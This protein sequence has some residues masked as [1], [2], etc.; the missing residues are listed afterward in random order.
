MRPDDFAGTVWNW[1]VGAGK[2][3]VCISAGLMCFLQGAWCATCTLDVGAEK[4]IDGRTPIRTKVRTQFNYFPRRI[5]PSQ[6]CLFVAFR[7]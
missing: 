1:L 7:Q 3:Q 4:G 5:L 6:P 2:G